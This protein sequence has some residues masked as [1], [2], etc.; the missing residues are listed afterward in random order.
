MAWL[1]TFLFPLLTFVLTGVSVYVIANW[2]PGITIDKC[3]HRSVDHD[4]DL[5][6]RCNCG[7]IY[8]FGNELVFDRQVTE[9]MIKKS[10][11]A[12]HTDVPGF[13]FLEIDGLGD[14]NAARGA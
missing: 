2:I 5:R 4:L 3:E 7:W 10:G 6:C 9:R 1:P 11:Q 12:I 14:G 8:S 13:L